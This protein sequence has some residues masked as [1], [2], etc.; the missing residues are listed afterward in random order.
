MTFETDFRNFK[1]TLP[2]PNALRG[3]Y[4]PMR[5]LGRRHAVRVHLAAG[6]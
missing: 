5:K 6:T 1:S 3:D 2:G 4:D